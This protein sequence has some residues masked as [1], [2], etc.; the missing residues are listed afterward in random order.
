MFEDDREKKPRKKIP[1]KHV[2]DDEKQRIKRR[3]EG[4]K[5]YRMTR[6]AFKTLKRE[7]P[8]VRFIP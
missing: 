2:S 8:H 5:C 4:E 7:F 3:K 6:E 1:W